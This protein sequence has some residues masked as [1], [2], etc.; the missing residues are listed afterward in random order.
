ML[1]LMRWA[2]TRNSIFAR[3]T[4]SWTSWQRL[5]VYSV[6]S[7]KFACSSSQ[8]WT[9]LAVFSS[10][11]L[12][13]SITSPG[14][15]SMVRRTKTTSNGTHWSHWSSTWRRFSHGGCSAAAVSWMLQLSDDQRATSIFCKR[16]PYRTLFSS[17]G[18]SRQLQ[19]KQGQRKSGRT[20]RW[21]TL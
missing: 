18:C 4:V 11:W 16:R 7:V 6:L 1:S 12:T 21:I 17:L 3:S 10:S 14:S 8:L 9:T 5:V 2:S 13:T 19:K 15:T 20:W